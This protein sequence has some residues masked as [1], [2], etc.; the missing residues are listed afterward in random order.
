M[1]EQIASAT[2][3]TAL[4]TSNSLCN[5]SNYRLGFTSAAARVSLHIPVQKGPTF[6]KEMTDKCGCN[7]LKANHCPTQMFYEEL[8]QW[9]VPVKYTES[10]VFFKIKNIGCFLQ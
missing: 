9:S 5:T 1:K 3:P 10:T 2:T 6:P 8:S 4:A 7:F